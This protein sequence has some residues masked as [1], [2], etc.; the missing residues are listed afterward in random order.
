N[1]RST[2]G[3]VTEIHDY[4]RVLYARVGQPHCPSCGRR[5]G[6]QSAEQ[7]VEGILTQPPGS[8]WLLLAPVARNR[9]GEYQEVFA[10]AKRDGFARVRVNG[11]VYSLD[12][13][14]RLNKKLK[15]LVDLVVDRVRLPSASPES[16]AAQGEGQA[17]AGPAEG[18]DRA[19]LTDSVETALRFGDGVLVLAPYG[20]T[21]EVPSPQSQVPRST[22]AGPAPEAPLRTS[23][24]GPRTSDPGG[25]Q[26]GGGLKGMAASAGDLLFSEKNACLYCGL[27]FDELSPQLFSFNSPIGA[28]PE[29]LGLGSTMEI[30]LDLVIPDQ[31]K[32]IR[33]GAVVPWGEQEDAS[34]ADTWG[35]RYR[36]QV[37]AHYGV[38]PD[39]PFDQLPEDKRQLL[40]HGGKGERVK[41]TWQHKNGSGGSWFSKWEGILPRLRRM[42]KQAS[43]DGARQHYMQF[44]AQ[45]P[46]PACG[47]AKLRPEARAVTVG[48]QSLVDVG[49]LSVAG[50]LA[51][52]E[53]LVLPEREQ[54]IA[55]ELLKEIRGRLGFLLNVG[56]HYLSLD[57]PAPTLS[58]GEAQRIRLASQ[59]G[60]GLVGVLY[61]LDEPSIGLHQR[62]NGKL[63]RTL[64]DLRDIG[65]TVVVV[66]HDLE[67]MQA[68]DHIVD[69]GPGAGVHGGQVVA[70]GAPADIAR[71]PESLTGQ[72]L[73]GAKEIRVPPTRR[74]AGGPQGE[75]WLTVRGAQEHNLKG[76]TVPFPLG[77]LT[78]VTGVSGSGKSSLVN[79]ILYKAL[80]RDL[81]RSSVRPGRHEGLDGLQHLDKVIA[82]DQ[83]P[84]G[85]T[86]RSNPATYTGVYDDIRQLFAQVPEA[87]IR[88]Y[89]PG[90]FS[91]NVKGGRCEACQ[92]DGLKRIEMQFLADVFVPC[93]VC[94]GKR[95]NR[96]TLE[97]RFK[98]KTIADVLGMT[99]DEAALLFEAVPHVSRILRTMLDVGLGYMHLGQPAPTLSG[100]EAQRIKLARELCRP[101]TGRTLYILDEP[102]TGLHFADVQKLLDVLGRL[103]ERGN[104]VVVIEHN[105]DVI[106]TADWVIDLGPEGGDGGGRLIA[107]GTPEAV[108]V[109]PG[110]VTGEYLRPIVAPPPP[111]GEPDRRL[112]MT[113]Q[114][115]KALRQSLGLTQAQAA[116]AVGV[117]RGLLAE[118]ER[119]RRAGERTLARIALGLRDLAPV[120][121]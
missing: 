121:S 15:H 1:P 92:G 29:C 10:K 114:S 32:T 94:A 37:L 69:F 112:A 44:F 71:C 35:E 113:P 62:D 11:R 28:C 7:I 79:E 99:I 91:F 67:T 95:F 36:A 108:A 22:P 8:E 110:S 75:A 21:S 111:P 47:G 117:S 34:D 60:C 77:V 58:G 85:R 52:F 104:T 45:Q 64:E 72:Y 27:S 14:I 100:G 118:A 49:R 103:V 66:E 65:N 20:T 26:S 82:I 54:T 41:I 5:V 80:E 120:T 24:F 13:E 107:A 51:Y 46:C 38:S 31:G 33:E 18:V 90:R 83:D 116:R 89:K 81:M 2:V 48:G 97:V 17:D 43:S 3:T 59:I 109:T 115:V 70:S 55:A 40:L 19:R 50:A 61:I 53:G 101:D 6:A 23:D 74:P 63:I 25:G 102:T 87:R 12:E 106:K 93:E 42:L 105:L 76:L 98:D 119:G 4:L 57:R 86:P 39:V 78:A 56:L 73:S 88:G 30:D 96:E 84:I 9:K 68:A 16:P